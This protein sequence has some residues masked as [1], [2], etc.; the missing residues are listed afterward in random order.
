MC[1]TPTIR[2]E[3]PLTEQ[4]QPPSGFALFNYGFRPFFLLAGL[5]GMLSVPM[6]V[7]LYAGH[8]DLNLV[9]APML[10]HGHEMLFG[11]TTA[12]IVGF[13]LTVVPNWTKVKARKGNILI[14]LS[15]LWL[16]G[17]VAF[18]AQGYIPYGL[19]MAIDMLFLIV[20]TALV[21]RPLIDPQYRRQLMFVPI[22]LALVVANA[23]THL[24]IAGLDVPGL[25]WGPDIGLR[26]LT[27]GLD[28]TVV[29]IAVMAG[30][31]TPSFTSS[32]LGHG[33]PTIKVLQRP[34]LERA[35][36][37]ATWAILV[38]DQ[39]LP[40][41]FLAGSVALIAAVLHAVRLSGWQGHRTLSNPILWVLHLGYV[42]LIAG[43]VLKGLSDF[44]VLAAADGV[45]ALTI[46]AIGTI[47]L[48]VM[49]RAALGHTGRAVKAAPAIV[50]AYVLV[51]VAALVRLATIVW[52]EHSTALVMASGLLWTAA[53]AV[54]VAVYAPVLMRP[55]L[56]G[57]PG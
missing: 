37:G 3:D 50:G 38:V 5:F 48:G 43:L 19:V 15:V 46:G 36:M 25:D 35:V 28:A 39:V 9:A 32:F 20:F 33:D 57:R 24:G 26:G 53:F 31:V 29:L 52:P 51:S 45:H 42:W 21:M 14:V 54:F 55:R 18:W 11:Y 12:A 13:L 7:G 6:W 8:V 40:V 41:S 22:L 30:R 16:A 47:T 10:W 34:K 17:R 56:D 23:M 44:G 2:I 4:P 1:A 27:L 49:T